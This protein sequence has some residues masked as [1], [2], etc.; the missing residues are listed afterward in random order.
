MKIL[1]L[2]GL[3]SHLQDDRREILQQYGEVYAPKID[4]RA[5]PNLFH[6]LQ[7]EYS[8]IQSI[9]GSSAG[10]LVAYY[11]AQSLRK[12]CLL[13]NPALIFRTEMPNYVEFNVSYIEYMRI[14]I[15][16]Q[17]EIINRAE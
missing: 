7:E 15:G 2:H 9:I 16:L 17:D 14:V 8:D 11:L 5:T 4:Y 6:L 3:D 1:Y 10:G 13:F 12:P